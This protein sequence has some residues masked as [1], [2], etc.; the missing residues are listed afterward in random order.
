MDTPPA[1]PDFKFIDD[2]PVSGDEPCPYLPGRQARHRAFLA[3]D[4]P[5]LAY[6]HLMNHGFRRSGDYFYRPACAGCEACIPIRVP[7]K[8]FV[9]SASQRRVLRRNQD[10]QVDM[11]PVGYSEE[12]YLL[13]RRYA[14]QWHGK[15]GV[16]EEEYRRFLVDSPVETIE[17]RYRDAG[18][19]L[20]AV[21]VCDVCHHSLS[22]VYFFFDPDEQARSLGTYGALVELGWA[23]GQGIP[24]YYL[25]Y[26]VA[27]SPA[28]SYKNRFGPYE[29]LSAGGWIA[30]Q[31]GTVD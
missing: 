3:D 26:W 2:L 27:G 25:G 21:G 22:S 31:H 13:Y 8:T 12:K 16:D 9:P 4:L 20:L 5:P 1:A 24:H 15:H 14:E 18:G 7:V 23:A 6:H 28:M 10:L 11:G 17:F 29:L 19:R 30:G